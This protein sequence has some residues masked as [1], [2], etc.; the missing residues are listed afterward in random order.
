[1]TQYTTVLSIAGSDGTCGAGIQADLKTFS[2]LGCYGLTV[3]TSLPIQNTQ[4]VRNIYSLPT[5]CIEEQ[6]HAIFEDIQVDTVKIGMLERT[7][8]IQCVAKLLIKYQ[9]ANIILDP[10]MYAKSGNNLLAEEAIHYLKQ[11]VIPLATVITPNI[12][13]AE[14]LLNRKIINY[15]D[16]WQ[17]AKYL[18]KLGC[19]SVVIKGGHLED[20]NMSRDLLYLNNQDYL[21]LETERISTQNTH[22]TGC[23]FS[24][25]IA[26]YIA[27]K[28]SVHDAF[29]AAKDYIYCALKAGSI[30][31]LGKGKGPV[32][33]FYKWS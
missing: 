7:D 1:M 33:H 21:W 14:K 20:K 8:I 2:A 5:Q 23:T 31:E 16:M 4:G 30:M 27:H 12:P 11:D 32:H 6:I 18:K 25:A 28:Y 9:V 3:L 19:L 13:E 17:A 22:G 29:K 15:D 26:S 24:S 10:V